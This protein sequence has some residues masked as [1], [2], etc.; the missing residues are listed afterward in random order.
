MTI[1]RSCLWLACSLLLS[2]TATLAQDPE[3]IT[4]T[5]LTENLHLLATDQGSYTT[6]S[7][8]LSTP[9]GLLLVD[10]Q[11]TGDGPAL[12]EVVDSYGQGTPKYIINTHRHG[13]H[14]GG[15]V[16]FGTDPVVI[17]HHLLPSKL[18]SGPE[19]FTEYPPATY[20]D[21]T[22]ADSLTIYFG[23]EV[24][25]IHAIAGSHD[26][27]EIMVHFVDQKVVHISSIVNGFNFPSVDEAGDA[28]KF[29]E[30]VRFATTLI[31]EDA[32]VV[33]GHNRNGT[34][35]D[36]VEYAAMLD[37]TLAAVQRGLESGKTVATMQEERILEPWEIY[38]G[39]Y[40]SEDDWIETLAEAMEPRPELGKPV[41]ASLYSTYKKQGASAA[42]D[43]YH[44]YLH[45]SGGIYDC[46]EFDLLSIGARL[47]ENEKLEDA[48]VFLEASTVEYGESE[49]TFYTEYLLADLY[50][51][52]GDADRARHHCDRSLGL[53]SDF[54]AAVELGEKL[55][56]KE[57]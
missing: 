27:N 39:S 35:A 49:Y 38:A 43:L 19:V 24:I 21:I 20:P 22:V 14:I 2:S 33:S 53:K 56:T 29:A 57:N 55:D 10:T 41:F 3:S 47:Q 32:T 16:Q 48:A 36:M 25:E 34:R 26:D 52:L 9:D 45:E 37:G 13:E 51:Q 8:L 6:N 5:K 15:N 28:L 44:Q 30:L 46:G 4:V 42:V 7:L 12:K 1:R 54:S 31:P 23:G 40:V 11:G 18:D 17:A 50:D